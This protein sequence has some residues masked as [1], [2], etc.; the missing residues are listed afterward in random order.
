[1]KD[2]SVRK[3]LPNG[4]ILY[5]FVLNLKYN[6]EIGLSLCKRDLRKGGN[7]YSI[8][9]FLWRVYFSLSYIK[10]GTKDV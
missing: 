9:L 7:E 1:M 10:G 2:R 3:I 8:N 5:M 4:N 6:E